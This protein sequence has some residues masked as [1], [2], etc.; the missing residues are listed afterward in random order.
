MTAPDGGKAD[1]HTGK[2]KGKHTASTGDTSASKSKSE[3]HAGTVAVPVTALLD[4]AGGA[5]D[6]Y[7]PFDEARVVMQRMS[8]RSEKEWR[9]WCKSG[10]RPHGIPLYPQR[11]YK[12]VGW[13][14][15]GH[16]LGRAPHR[17]QTTPAVRPH[18]KQTDAG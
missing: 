2:G 1:E 8:L 13:Q 7:L 16:W 11:M 12:Q 5:S 3:S 6:E 15:W 9:A 4:A 17:K 18:R 10:K 14:G